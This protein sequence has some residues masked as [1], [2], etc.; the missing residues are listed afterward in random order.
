ML[1]YVFAGGGA[2]SHSSSR[3]TVFNENT[4]RSHCR[5]SPHDG[6]HFI[7]H[8]T[9]AFHAPCYG[10]KAV[11]LCWNHNE[12]GSSLQTCQGNYSQLLWCRDVVHTTKVG[13][14]G[15]ALSGY[16]EAK[17]KDLGER[18][19]WAQAWGS[20]PDP[21][22]LPSDSEADRRNED[23]STGLTQPPSSSAGES[24][25]SADKAAPVPEKK[26]TSDLV[27]LHF[28]LD[29]QHIVFGH[30]A[31]RKLQQEKHATGLDTGCCYGGWLTALVVPIASAAAAAPENAETPPQLPP[32]AWFLQIKAGREYAPKSKPV[33]KEDR[34][35][36]REEEERL[37][38]PRNNVRVE[39]WR[40]GRSVVGNGRGRWSSR[41]SEE[42]SGDHVGGEPAQVGNGAA[43]S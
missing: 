23:T 1:S 21:P 25:S 22:L 2:G 12:R 11:L 18:L 24:S 37:S 10:R 17:S 34:E 27:S 26:K 38:K 42:G 4:V 31:V 28:P 30:D 14:G 39:R 36:M 5:L 13:S 33:S 35:K 43:Y 6:S 9:S 40:L 7:L 8:H 32:D 41:V 19:P 15:Q 16:K 29:S 3:L 20:S